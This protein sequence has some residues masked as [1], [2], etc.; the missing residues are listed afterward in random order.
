MS[1]PRGAAPAGGFTLLEVLVALALVAVALGAGL[2]AAG[3]LTNNAQRLA[4][5]TAAQWCADNQLT[6][7][8]LARAFPG[9]GDADFAC[10]QLGRS[11]AG[12]LRTRPTPN[13]G[14]RRVDA[15]VSDEDGR[16]LVTVSTVLGRP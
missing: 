7:L 5:V 12:Q 4:D 3:V 6:A 13:P 11:Y 8:R 9:V 1:A 15:V 16:P 14:F 10:E 2:R